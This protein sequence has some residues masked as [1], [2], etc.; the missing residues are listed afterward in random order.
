MF[1]K[2]LRQW[3]EPTSTK[4]F[5]FYR[6]G[7]TDAL[8]YGRRDEKKLNEFLFSHFYK[9]GYD[10]GMWLWNEQQEDK[11]EEDKKDHGDRI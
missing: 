9:R 4:Q 8:L 3:F 5:Q 10:F 11:D 1:K 6:D 7:T 2:I